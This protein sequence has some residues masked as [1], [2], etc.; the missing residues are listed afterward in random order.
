MRTQSHQHWNRGGT[1]AQPGGAPWSKHPPCAGFTLIELLVVIAIIAILAGMLLPTLGKVKTK[2]RATGCSNNLKQLQLCW[3]LYADDN[4]NVM[5]PN[6]EPL[7]LPWSSTNAWING[8]A[9]ADVNM[10]NIQNGLLFRYNSST[11]I[12]HCP[13]DRSKVDGQPDLTRARSYSMDNWLNGW[14]WDKGFDA[15][16][17]G[18]VGPSQFVK[19]TQLVN[20]GSSQTF[21]LIDEHEN[22]IDDGDF[23]VVH[24][25]RNQWGDTPADRHGQAANLSY[26]DGHTALQ[27]W[28]WPKGDQG[29]KWT[30]PPMNDADARDLHFLQ[31]R[32]PR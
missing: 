20:P 19:C 9:T 29:I 32:I 28:R 6:K 22:Y 30:Q 8:N 15:Y 13:A 4:N 26:A 21:V 27:R 23:P 7:W 12:Y 16:S 1:T 17:Y 10:T 14:D 31:N 24:A 2:A 18:A 5:A 25:P 11:A 3:T